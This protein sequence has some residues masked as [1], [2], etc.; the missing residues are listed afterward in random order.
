VEN[1]EGAHGKPLPDPEEA[2]AELGGIRDI[3]VQV[4]VPTVAA[5]RALV[6]AG[7]AAAG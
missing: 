7:Q 3:K 4:Q 1:A 2:I 6:D 5:A